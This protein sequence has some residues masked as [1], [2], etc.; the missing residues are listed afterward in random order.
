MERKDGIHKMAEAY[1]QMLDALKPAIEKNPDIKEG[2]KEGLRKFLSNLYI[3]Y[4]GKKNTDVYSEEAYRLKDDKNAEFVFEHIVPKTKYIQ[5]PCYEACMKG[6]FENGKK[7]SV[8]SIEELLDKY[9][10]I[11]TVTK[12]EDKKLNKYRSKMPDGWKPGDNAFA[13]YDALG[14]KLEK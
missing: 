1:F 6:Q 7:F 12:E 8:E 2:M 13:R 4:F 5:E 9:W 3:Y 11:A 14:I 10:K